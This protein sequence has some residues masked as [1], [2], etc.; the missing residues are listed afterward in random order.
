MKWFSFPDPICMMCGRECE[1]YEVANC[2][3][4]D[5]GRQLWCYCERCDVDTFHP[6]V[7]D[8]APAGEE[9]PR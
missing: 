5:G 3:P 6:P 7:E 8:A 1:R 9:Q 2:G 4:Y